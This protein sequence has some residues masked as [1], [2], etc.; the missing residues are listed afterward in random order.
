MTVLLLRQIKKINLISSDGV[1]FEVDYDVALMSKTIQ[2]AIEINPAGDINS[3][4]LSLVS[5]KILAKVIEYCKKHNN[6]Q[7]L[8]SSMLTVILCLISFYLQ[9]T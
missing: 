2:D 6:T 1:V 8:N 9:T 3:I 7:M 4:S 5:S